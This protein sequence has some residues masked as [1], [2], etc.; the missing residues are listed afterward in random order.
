[1]KPNG[2][3]KQRPDHPDQL[4]RAAF[5]QPEAAR[6]FRRALDRAKKAAAGSKPELAVEWCRY[7]A[8]VAWLSNPGLFYCREMEQLLSEI[9]R[10]YL[11]PATQLPLAGGSPKR[12]L[13]VMTTAFQTGGH[14][15]VVCRWIETC[16]QHSPSER[17]SVLIS[18]Q[19]DEPVPCWLTRSARRTE[20]ELLQLP[21]MPSWLQ[22][23]AEIRTKSLEFDVI[24]LHTHPN[25]PLPN[26]AFC[27]QPRPV[28]FYNH[29][30]HMFT[31]GMDAAWIVADQR[32]AGHEVSSILRAESPRKVLLPIPLLDDPSL[33]WDKAEAR[34]KLGL[35][36]DAPIA[37]TIG[38]PFKFSPALGCNFPEVVRCIWDGDPRVLVVAVGVSEV[39]PW[40]ELKRSTGGRFQPVGH[41]VDPKILECYYSAADLYLDSL[42]CGSQT[43]V[44]D[45]ARHALPVQRLNNSYQPLLW[46]D[47][48]ALDSVLTA[49]SDQS[50]YVAGVLQWLQW[51][52]EKRAELGC[53]LR[54]AVLQEHC[55]ASWKTRWLDPAMSAL[56]ASCQGSVKSKRKGLEGN[57]DFFQGLAGLEWPGGAASMF[58]AAAIL[59]AE[60]I[61]W[62]IRISGLLRSIKPLLLDTAH[63][64]MPRVRFLM[65]KDLIKTVLPKP[66]V[67]VMGRI[68]RPIV[69]R[70]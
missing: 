27:D 36:V 41:V 38:E 24:V 40:S 58:V 69:K 12:F 65:S 29:A 49:A 4:R 19:G 25:D 43:S 59:F 13:H 22:T 20:G 26:L 64:D 34:R 5:L 48:L 57:K 70:L 16:A 47:D 68:V 28:M 7:G 54:A 53:R 66:V 15:R 30:D 37:L 6:E 9:G 23:A 61:P 46:S 33:R 67:A 31:L 35:P 44:L 2:K 50:N 11:K 63:D 3:T 39:E 60:E 21:P 42:P 17:H 18:K 32:L 8:T 62:R 55:G 52:E 1:M 45:A 10:R 14:T 51:P 56:S